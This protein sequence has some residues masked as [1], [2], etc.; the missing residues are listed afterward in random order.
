MDIAEGKKKTLKLGNIDICRDFG[1]A[2][3]YVK[4]M[5]LM[6]QSDKPDNY[7]ICSGRSILLRN[8][9]QY[10]FEK[11][12]IPEN[13]L[14]ISQDLYRPAEI[15]DIYGD[16]AKAKAELNWEYDLDFLWILDQ[17]IEEERNNNSFC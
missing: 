17:L 9:V 15:I 7:V 16:S 8:I 6:L 12:N 1:Y 10:V 3:E 11:L 4:A 2:P 13:A 5:W 14:V